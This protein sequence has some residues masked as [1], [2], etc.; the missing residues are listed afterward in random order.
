[1]AALWIGIVF[2]TIVEV[3]VLLDRMTAQERNGF[4]VV[5]WGSDSHL[6]VAMLLAVVWVSALV[7]AAARYRQHGL[8]LLLTIPIWFLLYHVLV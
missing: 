4:V 6:I 7:W 3:M 2:I 5:P 1:M 8:W